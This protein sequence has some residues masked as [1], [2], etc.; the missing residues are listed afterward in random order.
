MT[1]WLTRIVP[2]MHHPQARRDTTGD[3]LGQGLHRRLMTLFPTDAGPD[4]RARFGVLFR[5]EDTPTGLHILLQSVHEPD[6]TALPDGYGTS[7]A[8]PLDTLLNA[9]RPGLTIRHRC[10]ANAVRK[11][12]A[13]TRDLYNLPA[14]V[15]LHGPAANSWWERQAEAAGLKPLSTDSHPLDA[16]GGRHGPRN[17]PSRKKVRHARTRF[18]GTAAVIDADLLRAK[19][20]EGIG[21]G[22]AYGCG[23]LTIAPARTPQ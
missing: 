8:R 19:I 20:T 16:A 14:V 5:A 22:K 18:D 11:P 23:L 4:P 17:S 21:R 10:I 1:V 15:P 13:T 9:L 6:L 3:A 2:D 7:R 12:G